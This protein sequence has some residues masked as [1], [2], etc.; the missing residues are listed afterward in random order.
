MLL[1]FI[2]NWFFYCFYV[3]RR[4]Y[5]RSTLYC[6]PLSESLE[7]QTMMTAVCP[8]VERVNHVFKAATQYCRFQTKD[9]IL[10]TWLKNNSR[11]SIDNRCSGS[12]YNYCIAP[13]FRGIISICDMFQQ[14]NSQSI[15]H[16]LGWPAALT[17]ITAKTFQCRL[18]LIPPYNFCRFIIHKK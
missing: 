10:S 14:L 2:S 17:D 18:K 1:N 3:I 6:W 12:R 11:R 5:K 9:W 15:I 16:Y 7:F 4:G 13:N 8:V